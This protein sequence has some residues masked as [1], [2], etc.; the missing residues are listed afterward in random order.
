MDLRATDKETM[1]VWKHEIQTANV[2]LTTLVI[3]FGKLATMARH[4]PVG[5][6]AEKARS[7]VVIALTLPLAIRD[8]VSEVPNEVRALD[9]HSHRFEPQSPTC[10][11]T[12]PTTVRWAGLQTYYEQ[13]GSVATC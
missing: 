12:L 10:S 6:V 13:L 2:S 11:K 9:V 7:D 4:H 1:P 3:C 5:V 8:I